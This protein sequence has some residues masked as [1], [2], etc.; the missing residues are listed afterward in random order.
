M[1]LG[2]S[3]RR[4]SFTSCLSYLLRAASFFLG[5]T[6]HP[7]TPWFIFYLD[8]EVQSVTAHVYNGIVPTLRAHHTSFQTTAGSRIVVDLW[9]FERTRYARVRLVFSVT[10]AFGGNN[11][12]LP[13]L[14]LNLF[15]R[16][17]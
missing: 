13:R 6:V 17:I 5:N 2:S 7:F 15:P 16:D 3:P 8:I 1:V 11:V 14:L 9:C 10:Y 12:A 4:A